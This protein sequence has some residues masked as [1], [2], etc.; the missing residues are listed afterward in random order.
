[1]S[2]AADM[3]PTLSQLEW[4]A[5]SAALSDASKCGCGGSGKPGPLRRLFGALT[6]NE[7]PGPLGDPRLEAVRSFVCE[8]NR[9]RRI[10]RHYVPALLGHGFNDRQVDALALLS[11]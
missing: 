5:V 6:G 9:H 4:Q 3:D 10:A 7:E 1:M 11:A 8:T 2:N